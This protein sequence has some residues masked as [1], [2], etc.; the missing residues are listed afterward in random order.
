MWE[1]SQKSGAGETVNKVSSVLPVE[2]HLLPAVPSF[3]MLVFAVHGR[4][5]TLFI[6]KL[7]TV[8][9]LPP[10]NG[11]AKQ[12]CA[13]RLAAGKRE[14]ANIR[15]NSI[16]VHLIKLAAISLIVPLD[17][18]DEQKVCPITAQDSL[19]PVANTASGNVQCAVRPLWG[20]LAICLFVS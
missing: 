5:G 17:G 1:R 16:K 11:L 6:C 2:S 15:N 18:C 9:N 14:V 13:Q 4:K 7:F 20:E 3:T 10:D 12:C 19:P 8:E